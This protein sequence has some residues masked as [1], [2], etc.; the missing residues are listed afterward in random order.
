MM[1]GILLVEATRPRALFLRVIFLLRGYMHNAQHKVLCKLRP[2]HLRVID[3]IRR[4]GRHFWTDEAAG[5]TF[6][7]TRS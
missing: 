6:R 5:T 7:S 2:G 4:Y 3:D 1:K